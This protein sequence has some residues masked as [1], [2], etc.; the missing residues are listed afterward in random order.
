MKKE[1][2][3]WFDDDFWSIVAMVAFISVLGLFDGKGYLVWFS[4]GFAGLIGM[5]STVF[6]FCLIFFVDVYGN[7]VSG[8]YTSYTEERVK[9]EKQERKIN[10]L[11]AFTGIV[12]SI[13]SLR[14]GVFLLANNITICR[15]LGLY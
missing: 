4:V 10:F 2:K 9:K 11:R 5:F 13:C 1:R 15:L 7:E 3:E 6:I 12:L 14:I 8:E